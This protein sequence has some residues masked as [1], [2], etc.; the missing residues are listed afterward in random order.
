MIARVGVAQNRSGEVNVDAGSK[1]LSWLGLR[2]VRRDVA[3]TDPLRYT[4]DGG[5]HDFASRSPDEPFY[6]VRVASEDRS[7]LP[8]GRR[9]DDSVNDIRRFGY[10]EQPPGI[11]RL[12]FAERSNHA[13][14]Q[15]AAELGLPWGPT[16]LRDHRCGNQ[17][18]NAKFQTDLVFSP[19]SPLVS[20]GGHENSGVVDDGAHA[21]RRT[22][23]D[24]RS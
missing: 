22:V 9:H 5:D 1:L 24:V 4:S 18:N 16:D 14:C 15:E 23:R 3:W 19:R 6:V 8:K 13:A 17:W 20:I 11:V 2:G 21:D 7:F 10:A 12:G